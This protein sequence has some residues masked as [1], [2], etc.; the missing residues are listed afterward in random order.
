[1]KKIIIY[2]DGG[3]R[4]NPGHSAIG[5]VFCNEKEQQVKSYGEYLG[6]NFTNNEAEYNAVIFALK[7]FKAVFGKN[8]AENSE[9]EVR[10]DSE[11]MV[12]QLNGEYKI[13]DEKIQPLFIAVWNLKLDFLKVKFKSIPREKN[14]EADRLAND[15]LNFQKREQRLV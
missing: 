9:I 13:L 8:L 12:K 6:D 10:S 11:L 7:K 14:K 4:G 3:S 2:T 15:A 1:M 5:V